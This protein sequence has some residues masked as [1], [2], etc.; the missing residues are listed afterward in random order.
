MGKLRIAALLA[1]A[2]LLSVFAYACSEGSDSGS[3][4]SSATGAVASASMSAASKSAASAVSTVNVPT[5]DQGKWSLIRL[6][7]SHNEGGKS[8]LDGRYEGDGTLTIT[9][10]GYELK[11]AYPDG[12]V[13]LQS[14][15]VFTTGAQATFIGDSTISGYP[16]AMFG[17]F[18]SGIVMKFTDDARSKEITVMGSQA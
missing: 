1:C 8:V 3:R 12:K 5:H 15:G 2:L 14:S 4:S 9:Q 13:V 16:V 18:G 17:G 7:Y 11:F 10:S 6:D